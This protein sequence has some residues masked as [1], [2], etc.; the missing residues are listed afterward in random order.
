M[1]GNVR[2]FAEGQMLLQLD[3]DVPHSP[4]AMDEWE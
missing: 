3:P 2:A 1:H 4:T